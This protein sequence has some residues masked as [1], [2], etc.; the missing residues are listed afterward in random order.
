LGLSLLG[1]KKQAKAK[2]RSIKVVWQ[3]EYAT[4]HLLLLGQESE[5][6]GPVIVH[7]SSCL[8]FCP[9]SFVLQNQRIIDRRMGTGE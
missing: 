7:A 8:F 4:N 3:Q 5:G 2:D 9:H 6:S 1:C